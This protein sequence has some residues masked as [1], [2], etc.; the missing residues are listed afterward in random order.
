MRLNERHAAIAVLSLV[1]ILLVG[2][3]WQDDSADPAP[4]RAN[5]QLARQVETAHVPGQVEASERP[6]R[7]RRRSEAPLGG[8]DEAPAP[9]KPVKTRGLQADAHRVDPGGSVPPSSGPGL[10]TAP[11][12]S[13]P[14]P[15][16]G[17]LDRLP[18]GPVLGGSAAP[19]E[20]EEIARLAT[21]AGNQRGFLVQPGPAL[22]RVKT[23]ASA[24]EEAVTASKTLAK[25]PAAPAGTT[26]QYTVRSGDSLSL[27]AQRECGT[28]RAMDELCRLNGLSD[29]DIIR[30]GMVLKL[31]AK[32]SS[33]PARVASKA[34]VA[35]GGHRTVTIRSGETLSLVL[36][37]EVGT[38][39]RSIAAVKRL[40]PD[41][42]PDRVTVGQSII[43]PLSSELAPAPAGA[44]LPRAT[45][46]EDP[47]VVS[48]SNRADRS[49]YV[50]R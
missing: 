40:N 36:D 31:P 15:R 27:I 45:A 39:K 23:A 29:R 11:G 34:P 5:Q 50:V 33:T 1:V 4:A 32:T 48:S 42:D 20:M 25:P 10:S 26:L 19:T 14:R 49:K 28:T 9:I 24:R 38:Y 17:G 43:L 22:D 16:A 30:E 35:T 18:V 21:K 8:L 6:P 44:A 37:R 47:R 3:F 12:S 46:S 7:P 2:F 13:Q 41:L